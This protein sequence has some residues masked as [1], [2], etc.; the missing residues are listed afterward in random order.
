MNKII[1]LLLSSL[2]TL[3]ALASDAP[4][5]TAESGMLATAGLLQGKGTLE[6]Q[7]YIKNTTKNVLTLARPRTGP[8][9]GLNKILYYISVKRSPDG[10]LLKPSPCDLDL[11]ELKPGEMAELANCSVPVAKGSKLEQEVIYIVS[12][13]L[14]NFYPLWTGTVSCI[15]KMEE[16]FKKD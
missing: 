3:T 2:I 1:I 11:I 13:E 10:K 8:S 12:D 14:K 5:I 16:R 7:I 4:V 9:S 15:S 6:I